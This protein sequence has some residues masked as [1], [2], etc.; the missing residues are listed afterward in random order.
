M[1]ESCGEDDDRVKE[2]ADNQSGDEE[3]LQKDASIRGSSGH[4]HLLSDNETYAESLRDEE[5]C[6]RT[7][8]EDLNRIYDEL[9]Q[10]IH[11]EVE[12]GMS[13]GKAEDNEAS[14]NAATTTNA[15]SATLCNHLNEIQLT[16]NADETAANASDDS[17]EALTGEVCYKLM[18][19]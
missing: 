2:E 1:T 17:E 5:R 16:M 19:Q 6:S 12:E 14:N 11:H 9:G 10:R 15:Q 4:S 18:L 7:A 13:T 8:L 3:S